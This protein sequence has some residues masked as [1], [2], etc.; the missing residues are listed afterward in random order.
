M[1]CENLPGGTISKLFSLPRM[2]QCPFDLF[3]FPASDKPSPPEGPL[4][5]SDITADSA[6]LT[7]KPPK[8]DGGSPLTGYVI[9][10]RDVRKT[11]WTKV[12]SV[13]AKTLTCVATK[14]LEG[15]PYLFR[16]MAVNKEGSSLPLESEDEI[17]PKKPAGERGGRETNRGRQ[18]LKHSLGVG[19]W[20]D[21]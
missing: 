7:W 8:S 4:V 16:V 17:V 19:G 1:N 9:E 18:R 13:D 10:K 6:T 20:E 12:A 11:T 2:T 5:A 21:V 3:F 15:T 14:L